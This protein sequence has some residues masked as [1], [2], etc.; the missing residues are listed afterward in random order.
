MTY[1]H[2][3]L[4][5]IFHFKK[6]NLQHKKRGPKNSNVLKK[7]EFVDGELPQNP[8]MQGVVSRRVETMHLVTLA[9]FSNTGRK[10]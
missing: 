6:E 5:F 9:F 2:S 10:K 7:S 1:H 8:N 4:R 3:K